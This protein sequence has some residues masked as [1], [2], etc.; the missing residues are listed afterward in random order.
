MKFKIETKRELRSRIN[1]LNESISDKQNYI[2]HLKSEIEFLMSDNHFLRKKKL[3]TVTLKAARIIPDYEKE[4]ISEND[5]KRE[6]AY[7]VAK[8]IIDHCTLERGTGRNAD[9]VEV[10]ITIIKGEQK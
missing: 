9:I 8:R 5:V 1:M 6:L 4:G 7:E 2:N 3:E 10:S